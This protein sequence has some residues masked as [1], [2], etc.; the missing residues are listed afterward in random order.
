MNLLFVDG[1][2]EDEAAVEFPPQPPP[3]APRLYAEACLL[4]PKR[5]Q[6]Y[7]LYQGTSLRSSQTQKYCY[8]NNVYSFI[9][10]KLLYFDGGYFVAL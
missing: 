2:G 10:S 5:R 3:P 9:L 6:T 1:R 4:A 7:C 8:S